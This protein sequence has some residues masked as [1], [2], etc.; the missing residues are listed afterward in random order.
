VA[1]LR[2]K[3]LLKSV[4]LSARLRVWSARLLIYVARRLLGC[5]LEV[6]CS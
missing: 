6:I 4:R 1:S 5:T 3:D 2:T